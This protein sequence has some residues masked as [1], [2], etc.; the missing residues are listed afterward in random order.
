MGVACLKISWR[1]LS[2]VVVKSWNSWRFYSSKIS[3]YTV[4]TRGLIVRT[5]NWTHQLTS[6]NTMHVHV[7][8]SDEINDVTH[9]F[10]LI[11]LFVWGHDSLDSIGSIDEQ[12]LGGGVG[13]GPL[14]DSQGRLLGPPAQQGPSYHHHAYIL[15]RDMAQSNNIIKIRNAYICV[16]TVTSNRLAREY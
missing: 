16:Y 9:A 10:N 13:L 15:Y 5:A 14:T 7:P 11:Y 1:K 2:R 12:V 3:R 4:A 6:G 8:F